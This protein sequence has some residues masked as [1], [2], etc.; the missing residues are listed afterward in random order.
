[1][2]RSVYLIGGAGAGKST[3][4]SWV[5]ADLVEFQGPLEDFHSLRNTKALVTLRGHRLVDGGSRDGLY[6]GCIR[7]SFPGTDGLDRAS[8]PVGEAWLQQ[9]GA[10]EFDFIVS[11]GATLATRRF[12]A[13]LQDHT[14]LLLVH[15]HADP[16][17]VQRRFDERGSKQ[18]PTFVKNTVTRS[19]NLLVD[20][21]KRGCRAI[22]IDTADR[23]SVE[24]GLDLVS[25]HLRM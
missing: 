12:L 5:M 1:M 6:L 11:E 25:R 19:R 22:S 17:T 16:E 4:T 9:G 15:L 8:S 23:D 7:E 10:G 20:M 2:T 3:F 14:D 18:D 24:L 13:A 21:E